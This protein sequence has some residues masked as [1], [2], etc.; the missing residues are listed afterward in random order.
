[1]IYFQLVNLA[2][3]QQR[4]HILREREQ[5]AHS[6]NVPMD[7][8]IAH[9]IARLREEGLDGEEIQALLKELF[10]VPVFTAHPTESKRRTILF[11]LKQIAD[12]LYQLNYQTLL[13]AEEDAIVQQIREN[14]VLLWQSDETRDRR[15]TVMDEVREGLF[16][17]EATLFHLVPRIYRELERALAEY[18]PDQQ[19]TLSSFLRYGSWIGGDRDGNPFV[20]LD[21]TEEAIREQKE[22]I[23]KLYNIEVDALYNNL[24]SAQTRVTISDA[25]AASIERD[26]TLVPEDEIEV[27]ER[28]RFEPYRQKLI[29]MFRRLRATRAMNGERWQ[30]RASRSP[31]EAPQNRRAY[32][33]VDEFLHDLYLIR[34]SLNANKGERLA[35]GRLAGLIR[36][37]EIF[38]FHLA[39]LDI[40]QHADRHRSA[41]TEVLE[42]YGIAPNYAEMDEA[43]RVALL[44]REIASERPLTARLDFSEATNETIEL[45]RLIRR[46]RQEV[47]KPIIE[48][49][50]ISMTTS[51]SN[52]LEVLLFARDA[53]LFGEIEVSPLFET[54]DDLLAAPRIMTAL[55]E[56]EIYR[57]HLAARGNRQQIMIGYSDSNKDGGYLR[58]N[59]MLFQAQRTLAQVCDMYG[60]QLTLFH[61]RGGTLGRGG[62]PTNRAILAQPPESVRGRIRVT[63]QGEVVSSRYDDE[64]IA[65]RHLE[66][67]VNA[68]LLSSGRRPVYPKSDL[69]AETMET[70]SQAAYTKY[71]SLVEKPNFV[72]YFHE[73]TPID[74]VDQLNIGSRPARRKK[75]EAIFDLRAIPWVFAWTQSRVNLPSWYGVGTALGDWLTDGEG[76]ELNAER[77]SALREMYQEW[78][79]F[80]TVLDNIQVGLGKAD[81]H[82]ARLYA[83]LADADLQAEIFDDLTA[84]FARTRTMLL[85]ITEMQELLDNEQWLQRSIRLRNPYVDPLNYIQ[86]SLLRELRKE[87][88]LPHRDL[89]QSGVNLSVNGIAAGLQ[90][91]G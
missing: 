52:L 36:A 61:G 80:R 29:M 27:L 67:L 75:T 46:A 85:A 38:G 69:W 42:R 47:G 14:V 6:Q 68:V 18:Y 89:L 16:Y 30:N 64:A 9:A 12:A 81:I 3:E 43:A 60:I 17:F 19:F 22:T 79:F 32:A 88:P 72:R 31:D 62:G 11:K 57:K 40:R 76:D 21:V 15:P 56:N 87:G 44:S 48:T 55:F 28:F 71:R 50:I 84:E 83:R 1:T 73:A 41:M 34:E 26:F 90:N 35:Q 24:S 58:A 51:V 23:L 49:Y 54:I 74:H 65:H 33:S 70:L 8:T 25:L 59:W 53:G 82:I 77:L 20:T 2:E 13:P 10:I 7:E 39:T 78:P 45:F 91:V 4:V 66:Q 37:A 86:V 63:E 5:R